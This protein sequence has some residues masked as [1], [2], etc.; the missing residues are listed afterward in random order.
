M[1]KDAPHC[2]LLEKCKSKV[3]WG[4]TSHWSKW[5][6]LK[7]LQIINAGEGVGEREPSYTVGGNVN[8]CSY[9]GEWCV[10]LCVHVCACMPAFSCVWLSVTPWTVACQTSLF[11][12]FSRQEYW[13]GLLFHSTG[14]L[15]NPGI[16][17]TSLVSCVG[18]QVIYQLSHQWSPREQYGGSLKP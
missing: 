5:P 9:Y 13:S 6:S 1:W 15:P 10:C 2:W 8:W 17:H 18:R 4:I 14:D 3:Q 11:M 16:K 12:E 7:S